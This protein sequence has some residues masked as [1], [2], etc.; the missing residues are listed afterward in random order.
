[1]TPTRGLASL[2][3]VALAGALVAASPAGPN[4][5]SSTAGPRLKTISSRINSN[6]ASLVI[7]ASDPVAYVATRPDPLTV[8][9]EFRNLTV[10]ASTANSVVPNARSPIAA[11]AVE[12]S[13]VLGA[14]ASR[15]RI[16]LTEPVGHH[17]RSDRNTLVV[18]FDK[19]SA[20]RNVRRDPRES[21]LPTPE[22][23]V[24][25]PESRVEDSFESR[26]PDPESRSGDSTHSN[27]T[28]SAPFPGRHGHCRRADAGGTRPGRP[29]D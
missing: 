27:G 15:V 2:L 10:D 28:T 23:R 16:A 3:V 1:M 7:E 24:P 5:A 8:V 19:V 17:V 26:I 13:D 25:N 4:V 18:D 6:G 14:Q 12:P 22:S 11:V 9:L 21:Q 20:K 29:T